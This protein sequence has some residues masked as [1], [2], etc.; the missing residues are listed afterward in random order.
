MFIDPIEW[1][2]R[3]FY[4]DPNATHRGLFNPRLCKFL[5]PQMRAFA[6][7]RVSRGVEMAG[8]QSGKT[9]KT[10]ICA[11]WALDQDPA[12]MMWVTPNEKFSKL[13]FD[14]RIKPSLDMCEPLQ[15]RLPSNRRG[16]SKLHIDFSTGM[17]VLANAGSIADLSGKPIRYLILDCRPFGQAD[18]VFDPRR[19]E[20][21]SARPGRIRASPN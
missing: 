9:Q 7:P 12:S 10:L 11:F 2:A 18:P 4:L 13:F 14:T 1:G 15:R 8:A 21:L 20:R 5:L 3:Y 6:D 19:G 17:F 16:I